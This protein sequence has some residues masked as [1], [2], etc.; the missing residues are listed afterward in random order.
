MKIAR[1][2]VSFETPVGE[3]DDSFLGDF[4]E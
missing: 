2:P 4:I 1:E 3:D